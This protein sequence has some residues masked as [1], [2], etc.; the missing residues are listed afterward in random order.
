MNSAIVKFLSLLSIWQLIVAKTDLRNEVKK[1]D[2]V[3]GTAAWTYFNSYPSCCPGLPNYDANAPT[4]QCKFNRCD[5]VG[6]FYALGVRS[7]DFVQNNN[8]VSFYDHSDPTGKNF[9]SKYG[10]RYI[11]VTGTCAGKT[12]TFQ[13]L[14]GDTCKDEL[15]DGCCSKTMNK[16]TGYLISAEYNTMIRNFGT[17]AC[18]KSVNNADFSID[19]SQAMAIPNCGATDGGSCNAPQTCCGADNFCNSGLASCGDG[20]QSNYGNCAGLYS[21]GAIN[22]ASCTD[23]AASCCSQ[24]GYCANSKDACGTGCQ[25]AYG[26][27]DSADPNSSSGAMEKFSFAIALAFLPVFNFLFS[28]WK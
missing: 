3:A 25:S 13:A 17:T 7:Q 5:Q 12:A 26:S 4:D 11:T 15:C 24:Y 2:T 22:E 1:L 18:G 14:V 16:A 23:P 28:I 27:C 19:T 9:Y 6:Y 8:I 21:C 10:N 20:C